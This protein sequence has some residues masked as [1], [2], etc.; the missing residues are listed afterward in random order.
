MLQRP[1]E[2]VAACLRQAAEAEARAKLT[3]DAK[4]KADYQLIAD[5]WRKLAQHN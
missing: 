2:E 3:N 4:S 5:T 1:T